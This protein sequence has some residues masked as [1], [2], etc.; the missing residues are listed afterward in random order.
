MLVQFV[1]FHFIIIYNTYSLNSRFWRMPCKHEEEA[2]QGGQLQVWPVLFH[3]KVITMGVP[4]ESVESNF[5]DMVQ[6]SLRT[7]RRIATRFCSER[8][9]AERRIE[10][11]L[12]EWFPVEH[13]KRYL[14][15][16]VGKTQGLLIFIMVLVFQ[17]TLTHSYEIC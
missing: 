15:F 14:H 10:V 1:Y 5:L 6:C 11:W 7:S 4:S 12:K 3:D 8:S 16:I 2:I 9:S 17:N 13:Y